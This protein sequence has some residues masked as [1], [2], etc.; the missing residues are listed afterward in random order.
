[1]NEYLEILRAGTTVVGG[2]DGKGDRAHVCGRVG[3]YA[4]RN[5]GSRCS[6]GNT[7]YAASGCDRSGPIEIRIGHVRGEVEGLAGGTGANALIDRCIGDLRSLPQIKCVGGISVTT[8]SVHR[9]LDR[10]G[11]IG[12]KQDFRKSRSGRGATGEFPIGIGSRGA[13]DLPEITG[14]SKVARAIGGSPGSHTEIQ[15]GIDRTELTNDTGRRGGRYGRRSIYREG[16]LNGKRAA[17][18]RNALSDRVVAGRIEGDLR[19]LTG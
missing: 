8:A 10:I 12:L 11:A 14:G 5:G 1:M 13:V 9:D 18:I 3:E 4:S 15:Y 2:G 7:A 6:R 16:L 17:T 19:I